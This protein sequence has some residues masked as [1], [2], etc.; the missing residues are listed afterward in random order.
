[1]DKI[2][3]LMT[4]VGGL[5]A[6][7]MIKSLRKSF[8]R[9]YIVG[10]DASPDAVGFHFTD[11]SYTVLTGNNQGYFQQILRIAKKENIDVIIPLSDE[12][13]LALAKNK[14]YFER[15]G[16]RITC[17]DY[18]VV[19]IASNKALMLQ[20]LKEKRLPCAKYR[21]PKNIKELKIAVKELGYPDKKVVFKPQEG[22]G[23]RGLWFINANLNRQE[24][25]LKDRD[26]QE[27]TLEWLLEALDNKNKFP[28]ILVM[29]YLSGKDFN[30]DVLASQGKSLF[31]IPNERILPKAGPVQIGL[32]K[33]DKRV[34]NLVRKVIKEFGFNYYVNVEVAYRGGYK[35]EPF[36]YEINP[37]VSAPITIN[38]AAG[39]NLLK[40]GIDLA[41][42]KKIK[43]NKNFRRI[44]MIRY[45]DEIFVPYKF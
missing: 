5:V 2:N 33:K 32:T 39:V 36:V 29:E 22:R 14:Y 4:S 44:K 23:A 8:K 34:Q 12:E 31:I 17:S 3:I 28:K 18:S 10:V 38:Q 19:K 45:W 41:L 24:M 6:P 21:I 37:R 42:N 26:R 1:M 13:V 20:F 9:I 35:S 40:M 11:K 27:I 25:I 15:V 16:I 7:G 30:V 43:K